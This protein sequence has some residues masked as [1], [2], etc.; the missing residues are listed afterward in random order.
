MIIQ[1]P[2]PSS[3]LYHLLSDARLFVVCAMVAFGARVLLSNLGHNYDFE[4][5]DMVANFMKE[6]KNVYAST[7]RYN[8][9]PCWMW[10]LYALKMVFTSHFRTALAVF[11]SLFDV[12]IAVLLFRN[13]KVTAAYLLLLSPISIIISGYHNQFDNIAIL[14]ALA[15]ALYIERRPAYNAVIKGWG[16]T[17]SQTLAVAVLLGLSLLIKHVLIFFPIWL[18]L[19]KRLTLA[20]K[21][22]LVGIPY[23]LF[24]VSFLPYLPAG[25]EGIIA[26]VLLYEPTINAPAYNLFIG[27]PILDMITL[28]SAAPFRNIFFMSLIVSGFFLRKRPLLDMV[29]FYCLLLV[30]LSSNLFVHYFLIPVFF[31]IIFESRFWLLYN[32]AGLIFL[33]SHPHEF[34]YA[35]KG[36]GKAQAVAVFFDHN[37]YYVLVFILLVALIDVCNPRLLHRKTVRR[38]IA[39]YL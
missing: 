15:A 10:I 30:L 11:I 7:H 8:Y 22:M 38:C 17:T 37:G 24:A 20:Q 26:N 33:I 2:K 13:K 4:S 23:A 19:H 14:V 28:Y 12:V 31:F 9:S 34:N 5:W 36:S 32:L 39:P 27:K 21:A 18:L 1:A 35:G 29:A 3:K 25:K 16:L 6:G